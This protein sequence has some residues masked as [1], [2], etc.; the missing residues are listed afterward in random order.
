MGYAAF[1][2][3]TPTLNTRPLGLTGL[4][5]SEISFGAGPVAAL[6]TNDGREAQFKAIQRALEVGINW[7]DTAATYGDGQSEL[8][9]AAAL[10]ELGAVDKVHIATK[11]RLTEHQLDNVAEAV[12][13]SVAA[14]LKRLGLARVTLIQLHNSITPNRG[15]QPTSITPRDALGRR[16]VLDAFQKLKADGAVEHFGLT[17]LGAEVSLREVIAA[18][19]WATIQLPFNLLGPRRSAG[20]LMTSCAARGMAVLA[21]RVFAGGALAGQPPSAHTLQ[22]KF[23]PLEIY[24]RDVEQSARFA[25]LL[26]ADVSLKEVAVRYVLG[27]GQIATAL[28]GFAS[29]EQ[30]DEAVQFAQ[31]GLLAP[32]MVKELLA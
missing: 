13:S 7:F 15:D 27:A 10:R 2:M 1:A 20:D 30:I 4:R 22:T 23:F 26:P 14:S 12:R 3:T 19:S 32:T 18:G 17:G 5:I 28:I 11:V 31:A 16:G 8:N 9:L 24:R 6:M 25:A 29:A 21:I